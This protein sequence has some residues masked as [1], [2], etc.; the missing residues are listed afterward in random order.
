M[1]RSIK[2]VIKYVILAYFL[3]LI[4]IL[5]SGAT[6]QEKRDNFEYHA[7]TTTTT[8]TTTTTITSEL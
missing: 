4:Q 2:Y 5:T 6:S 7:L 8:T 3:P 1:E